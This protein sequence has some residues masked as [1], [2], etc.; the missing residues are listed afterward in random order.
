MKTTIYLTIFFAILFNV[1]A[2]SI[3]A[4]EN[5]TFCS[6]PFTDVHFDTKSFW[7]KRLKINREVSIPHNYKWC[8]ETGRFTNFAKAAKLM[9]GDF[10]GIY[11]ND[12]DV[13]KL[14]EGI[15]YSL[16]DHPDPALEKQADD[17]IAWIAAA[18]QPDGYLNSYF[19][20]REQDKKWTQ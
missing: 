12:S 13:Y 15:A 3:A 19:S 6:V 20:L 7:A 2:Q 10:K 5:M 4:Q 1:F 14:L 11:F 9:G 8:E 16:A 18:Q 17:V